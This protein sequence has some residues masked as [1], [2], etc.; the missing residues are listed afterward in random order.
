MKI[1]SGCSIKSMA[2][3]PT[4][5]GTKSIMRLNIS[6]VPVSLVPYRIG[7]SGVGHVKLVSSITSQ[8]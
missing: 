7:S 8:S 1:G 5:F 2:S 6:S 4:M 3:S